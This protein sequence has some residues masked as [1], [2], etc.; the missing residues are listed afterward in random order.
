MQN[1]VLQWLEHT[2]KIF[3]NHMA[4][5]DE[6]KSYTWGEF[7]QRA[8]SI[9]S[10]IK[11]KLPGKKH[12][13]VVYMEKSVDMLAAFLGTAYSGNFYSPIAADM[14]ASRIEKIL[15]TLQPEALITTKALKANVLTWE[16]LSENC[17]ILCLE[18]IVNETVGDEQADE[19]TESILD[20]DLLYVLFTS[21]STGVPKGVSITHRSVID[22]IDWVTEEFSITEQDTF[23]NQAPFYFDNSV[24]DIYSAIKTG[25]T[26]YITPTKLFSQPVKLLQYLVDNKITTI[27]WVPSAMIVISALR[28]LKKVDLTQTVKRV[29]FAGEVMPNK[30]LNLWRKHLP[31]AL[32]VNCYGPT[33]ITDLCT[34]YIVDREFK[35]DEPLPIGGQT[36]MKNTEIMVLDEQDRLITEPDIVGEL[37][38]RGSSLAV[39]YYNNPEKTAQAFVQNPLQKA[40]EEKI[41]RTG[42]LVKYNERHEIIYLSRKDFQIKH[43]GHRIELGEIENAVSSFEEISMC[44]CLYDERHSVIVL[45][46]EQDMNKSDIIRR[47]QKMIPDYMLPGKV[48]CVDKLPINANGKIDRVELRENYLR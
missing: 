13:I 10:K 24:L 39:G 37:C 4:Y 5:V 36:P 38:V 45:F 29:L 6:N 32:Y 23:G 2:A 47:L 18:D 12:P 42:D 14:P 26:V 15:H 27:F 28:A 1:S 25:A 22:F 9:A 30:H 19:Y 7:R 11:T 21:G 34:Y 17:N 40:Y 35:D 43:L 3:P 46:L 20:T 33:E 8:L 31:N 41:Y 48:V 44:C 16:W